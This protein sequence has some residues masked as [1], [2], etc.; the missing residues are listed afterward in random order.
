MTGRRGRLSFP[1]IPTVF[2]GWDNTP[3]RGERGVIIVGATPERFG[4][5]LA[6]AIDEVAAT[7]A[8]ERLVFVNAWNEWAEGNYLEPDLVSGHAYLEAVDRAVHVPA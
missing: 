2:V 1:V 8:E 6:S 4:A 7:P 3:R 5:A